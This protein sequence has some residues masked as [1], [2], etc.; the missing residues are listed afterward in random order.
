MFSWKP[1]CSVPVS[2]S[3]TTKISFF[4]HT[5]TY[6]VRC[7]NSICQLLSTHFC[8]RCHRHEVGGKL[9]LCCWI[10]KFK[11]RFRLNVFVF[12]CN[13]P[14]WLLLFF[15]SRS[16]FEIVVAAIFH[17]WRDEKLI[18]LKHGMMF[19]C[20]ETGSLIICP[21]ISWN[22]ELREGTSLKIS[23]FLVGLLG[24]HRWACEIIS[25][26]KTII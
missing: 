26:K 7:I 10:W 11:T 22:S 18:F 6:N 2:R 24:L 9:L 16:W 4:T 19:F 14:A 23:L 1:N 13:N 8:C 25:H 3:S 5:P 12:T 21:S 20:M 15:S 17:L